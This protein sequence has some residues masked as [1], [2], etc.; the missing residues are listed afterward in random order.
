MVENRPLTVGVVGGF[1]SSLVGLLG[2][3]VVPALTGEEPSL[4]TSA[5]NAG[6][7]IFNHQ[8]WFHAVVLVL[9]PFVVAL[10][11]TVLLARWEEADRSATVAFLSGFLW[12]QLGMIVVAYLGTAV[13]FGVA[14]GASDSAS[15]L[16]NAAGVVVF[17]GF[18]LVFGFLAILFA[19]P[20]VFVGAGIGWAGGTLV[21][22]A[23]LRLGSAAESE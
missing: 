22:R 12:T 4:L 18:A 9:P 14:I 21:A 13:V 10:L 1:V 19:L 2:Y 23:V 20:V 8:P 17:T 16:H 11:G 7:Y 6:F 5:T 15:R 3:V